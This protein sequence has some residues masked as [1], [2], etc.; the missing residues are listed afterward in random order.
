MLPLHHGDL[1]ASHIV[2]S[3]TFWGGPFTH[4]CLQGVDAFISTANVAM[5]R[6]AWNQIYAARAQYTN[7]SR[8][9]HARSDW[10]APA[11][12]RDSNPGLRRRTHSRT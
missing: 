2:R 1:T 9:S 8:Q 7:L 6:D 5:L 4:R 10:L 12:P 11:E 3:A